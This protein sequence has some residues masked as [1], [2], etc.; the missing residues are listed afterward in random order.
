MFKLILLIPLLAALSRA[1]N[2]TDDFPPDNV[3]PDTTLFPPESVVG[4]YGATKTGAEG[5]AYQTAPAQPKRYA[6]SQNPYAPVFLPVASD[7]VSTGFECC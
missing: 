2:T 3:Q 6:Q 7:A 5:F 4:Y 1:D